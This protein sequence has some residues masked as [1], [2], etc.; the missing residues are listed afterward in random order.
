MFLQNIISSIS[1]RNRQGFRFV[2][3]GS[4]SLQDAYI[5]IVALNDSPI[6]I[7]V[8]SFLTSYDLLSDS[9]L[10]NLKGFLISFIY[11]ARKNL[12]ELGSLKLPFSLP[13]I[14]EKSR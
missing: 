11:W 3:S 2:G 6:K 12:V 10:L 8:N 4:T 9:L 14:S 7:V 1:A 5:I 13:V